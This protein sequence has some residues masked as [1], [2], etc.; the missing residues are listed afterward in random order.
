MS[1]KPHLPDD[2]TDWSEQTVKWYEAWRSS[3]QTDHWDARH[4]EYLLDTAIVHSMVYGQ[5]NFAMLP[6]LR[7]REMQMGLTFEQPEK[8]KP[9]E[10][11]VTAFD[12]IAEQ[13][14]KG[15]SRKSNAKGA[16][17]A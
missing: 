1:E 16:S 17:S 14:A 12:K 11:R 6:E 4:W 5:F 7:T 3:P 8:V 10:V 2:L 13:Y 15:A 9:V